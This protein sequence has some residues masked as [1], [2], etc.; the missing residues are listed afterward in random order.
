MEHILDADAYL[1][2]IGF[3]NQR[4]PVPDAATLRAL[5]R[6]HLLTVP[7]EN[8]DIHLGRPIVLDLAALERK[9]VGERRGGFCYELNGTFAALLRQ[10]GYEVW[11]L[12]A[13]VRTSEG[14]GFG[15]PFD[16]LLL[17]VRCQDGPEEWLADVGFGGAAPA[18][19]PAGS[20]ITASAP[21]PMSCPASRRCATTTRPRRNRRS[22]RGASAALRPRPAG[23]RSATT[24]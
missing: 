9:L 1:D 21:T 2:R 5:H 7:F 15:P 22:P 6:A 10:L 11:L 19:P 14:Q 20:P 4:P 8:L 23:A 3:D 12:E 18:T 17:R 16:H 13:R 24:G